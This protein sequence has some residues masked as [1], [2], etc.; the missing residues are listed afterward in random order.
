MKKKI[1]YLLLLNIFTLCL[2]AQEVKFDSNNRIE[3]PSTSSTITIKFK[4]RSSI[5]RQSEQKKL[6]TLCLDAANPIV[7]NCNTVYVQP[8]E[9]NNETYYVDK[10]NAKIQV[11]ASWTPEMPLK[12]N[13]YG[14]DIFTI[15]VKYPVVDVNLDGTTNI[16][17]YMP[18]ELEGCYIAKDDNYF[19]ISYADGSILRQY[20]LE[21]YKNVDELVEAMLADNELTQ[22]FEIVKINTAEFLFNDINNFDKVNL[23]KYHKEIPFVQVGSSLYTGQEYWDS[24]PTLIRSNDIGFEHTLQFNILVEDGNT[25]VIETVF[26][27]MWLHHEMKRTITSPYI[28]VELNDESFISEVT[29]VQIEDYKTRYIPII[30]ALH[31]IYEGDYVNKYLYIST[32]RLYDY[33]SYFKDRGMK[34]ISYQESLDIL[35]G[36]KEATGYTYH[37][38]FDDRQ[39]S[40]WT[41]KNVRAIFEKFDVKPTLPYI[42]EGVNMNDD[43]P[44][45]YA[46]SQD[47]Y[48]EMTDAGWGTITHGF[49]LHTDKLSY[50][51]FYQGFKRT[52]DAWKRWYNADINAYVPHD[53]FPTII[54]YHL[55][56]YFGIQAVTPSSN[57]YGTYSK[58]DNC[59]D[60]PYGRFT[61]LDSEY[62]WDKIELSLYNWTRNDPNT[63]KY[64]LSIGESGWATMCLYM[65]TVIPEGVDVYYVKDGVKTDNENN[66]YITLKKI[67]TGI[68]P[69]Q[70]GVIV[71]GESGEYPFVYTHSIASTDSINNNL[72]KGT[73]INEYIKADANTTYYVLAN[74]ENKVGLYQAQIDNE[75]FYNNENKAYLPVKNTAAQSKCINFRFMDGTTGIE[76]VSV[77]NEKRVFDLQGRK[78]DT[79]TQSGMYIINGKKQFIR[80]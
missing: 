67:T 66:Q 5:Y 22:I 8:V 36:K 14:Q 60:M 13:N 62:P 52:K 44:P 17:E 33:M 6:F 48:K 11:T 18:A 38:M 3:I 41:N 20:A 63:S 65:N 73:S 56:K 74:V 25:R 68:I 39:K 32:K 28:Q 37:L 77:K 9:D 30:N 46:L 35:Q 24:Y 59:M 71:R 69:A 51:Q 53:N 78:I 27:G 61:A 57:P 26:D 72:L 42:I 64:N 23:T 40:H 45:S 2:N 34:H 29:S 1:Y 16:R 31:Y 7:R 47:E 76:S 55:L 80:L 58:G 12:M 49:T 15:R 54:Q 70:Q 10:N 75:L 19:T 50:A 4:T 43:V 21:N 79:I